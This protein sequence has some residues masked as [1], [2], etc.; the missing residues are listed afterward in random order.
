MYCVYTYSMYVGTLF[1]SKKMRTMNMSIKMWPNLP[2][3]MTYF[4]F[5]ILKCIGNSKT[6]F[7]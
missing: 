1:R 6:F 7:K 2:T 5:V 3:G 4:N